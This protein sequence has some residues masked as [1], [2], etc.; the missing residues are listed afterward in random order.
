MNGIGAQVETAITLPDGKLWAKGAL[1]EM[2]EGVCLE[3]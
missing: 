3:E 1:K 2:S